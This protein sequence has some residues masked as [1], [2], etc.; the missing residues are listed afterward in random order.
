MKQVVITGA[1]G[2]LG[3][4]LVKEFVANGYKVIAIGRNA[5]RLAEL[6]DTHVETIAASLAELAGIKIET[7][8][9][10]HAAALSTVWGSWEK[11]YI[12]NVIL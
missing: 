12:N 8:F 5:A 6:A 10:V 4:Y 1:T 9:V 2:F 7:D 11:F 3:G